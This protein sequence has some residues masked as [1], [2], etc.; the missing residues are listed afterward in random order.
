MTESVLSGA[1]PGN[2]NLAR[3]K[4]VNAAKRWC[5]TF[6]NYTDFDFRHL[7]AKIAQFCKFAIIGAEKAQTGTKHLQGYFEFKEKRRPIG[8]FGEPRIH[9][10]LARGSKADNITYCSKEKVVFLHPQQYKCK[11]DDLYDW[12]KDIVELLRSSPNDRTINWF[13]EPEGC[14]G[15]TTFQKYV[16]GEFENV[17][18]LSGKGSDMKNGVLKYFEATQCL[19]KIVLI[20]VPRSCQQYVSYQ[21]IEEI[22]D[23]FFFSPK[24]E[25]GMVCGA[26]PHVVIFGNVEPDTEKLSSDRWNIVRLN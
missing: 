6:N 1:E 7:C 19:P 5:F 9:F 14:T 17:V 23:M 18:V 26:S 22:K 3:K 25:G 8:L 21:G 4:R 12:E 10:E 20:N 15:K 24:Y 13:W 16:Y 2:T 11:I